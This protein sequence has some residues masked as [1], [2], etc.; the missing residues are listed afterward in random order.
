[1]SAS[2]FPRAILVHGQQDARVAFAC[3]DELD[4]PLTLISSDSAA[5]YAGAAWFA[6]TLAVVAA[7]Y[8][9][10]TFTAILDCGDRAGD[11]QGA[12]ACG[13]H[14]VLFT[15]AP[16]V[17]DRLNEIGAASA[18]AVL[19]ERPDTLDLR[20]RHDPRVVCRAWLKGMAVPEP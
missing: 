19:T 7:G 4:V 5:A 10:V 18:A 17:A 12:F 2:P 1:M 11:A 6:T 15:G 16:T 9:D 13:I 3:A 14:A 8:P 20:G